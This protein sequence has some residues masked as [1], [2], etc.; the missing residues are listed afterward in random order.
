MSHDAP[1]VDPDAS[2]RRTLVVV[3]PDGF[4][5]R[6]LPA[7]GK[8]VIGRALEC[9]VRLDDASVS[10]R[11]AVLEIG[12]KL[13]LVVE[14]KTGRVRVEGREVVP[15][16]PVPIEPGQVVEIGAAKLVVR[17]DAPAAPERDVDAIAIAAKSDLPVL[18]LGESG[19][20]K[21]LAMERI[22]AGSR[23]KGAPLVRVDCAS[24][25][26]IELLR[27]RA[28]DGTVFFDHVAELPGPVQAKLLRLL[29]DGSPRVIAAT[30]R[31]LRALV[32]KGA[33][34]EDAYFRLAGIV[35]TVPPLRERTREIP[36][37]ARAIVAERAKEAGREPPSI[38][39]AAL[40]LLASYRW[41]G[42]VRELAN[43]LARALHAADRE[44]RPEHL[45]LL[46]PAAESMPPSV[47]PPMSA[48]PASDERARIVEALTRANGNQKE[49]ARLL[50]MTRRVLMYRLDQYAIPRPRKR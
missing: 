19:A 8:L 17:R 29:E 31:D 49:A 45:E 28:T 27:D 48:P 37:L 18:L 22:V 36:A 5:A 40:A 21:E 23:R 25:V 30:N 50:G 7:S 43:V 4:F 32:A 42:N 33:F 16:A 44:I 13:A 15:G 20:G 6:E 12:E 14:S 38:S 11:H 47:A 35:V 41:P 24:P 26:A 1:T 9:D 10:R 39:D 34:R 3:A 2:S 46:P